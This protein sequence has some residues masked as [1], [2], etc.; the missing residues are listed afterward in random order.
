MQSQLTKLARSKKFPLQAS[1]VERDLN[2]H[3][4]LTDGTWESNIS[5]DLLIDLVK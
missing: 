2:E 3:A 5:P 1:T 4:L